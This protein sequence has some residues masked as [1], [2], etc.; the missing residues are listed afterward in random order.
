MSTDQ[1]S[2][3][4]MSLDNKSDLSQVSLVVSEDVIKAFYRKMGNECIINITENITS[5]S[6]E[7]KIKSEKPLE[8]N[9]VSDIMTLL[10]KTLNEQKVTLEKIVFSS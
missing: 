2:M 1:V 5:H 8:L 4:Y 6:L 9:D 10:S 3:L 7:F